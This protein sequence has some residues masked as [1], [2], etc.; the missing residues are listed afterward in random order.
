AVLSVPLAR[1]R[2][3]YFRLRERS[4]GVRQPQGLPKLPQRISWT[5]PPRNFGTGPQPHIGSACVVSAVAAGGPGIA[6]AQLLCLE[7]FTREIQRD[8]DHLQGFR[9]LQLDVGPGGEG[10]LLASLLLAP[11]GLELRQSRG[12]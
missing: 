2:L 6:V 11:T 4:P 1:R 3:R 8:A 5:G 9:S 10:L 7:R 12:P